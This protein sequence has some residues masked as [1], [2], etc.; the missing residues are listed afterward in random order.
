MPNDPVKSKGPF[1]AHQVHEGD[2]YELSRGNPIYCA[3][4]GGRH[5]SKSVTGALAIASDPAVEEAGLDAGFKSD[6]DATLRAP[7]ISVGNVPDAPGW[8]RGAPPLAVEYADTG[9]DEA[10]L[11]DR[12]RDLHAG[13]TRIIWVVRLVGPQRVEIHEPDQAARVVGIDDELLAPGILQNPVP[14]RAL[15]DRDTA[16][17]VTL[18]NLLQRRGYEGIESIKAEGKAE[19]RAEGKAEGRAEGKAEGTAA[20]IVAVLRSR[21]IEVDAT[22]ERTIMSATDQDQLD[23]WLAVAAMVEQVDDLF[24]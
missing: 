23:R 12:I 7:D 14:V 15:F 4:A 6:D 10:D 2:R 21:G 22:A 20:A 9:Q 3:P 24:R 19:G 11:L 8:V 16:Q 13:G 1:R 18:R 17:E 5:A